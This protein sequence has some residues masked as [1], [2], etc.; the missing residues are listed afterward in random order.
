MKFSYLFV[1]L[2]LF[3]AAHI[4]TYIIFNIIP[5]YYK[6]LYA[7]FILFVL[8]IVIIDNYSIMNELNMV[9][10]DNDETHRLLNFHLIEQK[11]MQKLINIF[12]TKRNF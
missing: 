2:I 10:K 9:K 7:S 6:R 5:D 1:L 11:R 4:L 3:Y 8:I 12:K